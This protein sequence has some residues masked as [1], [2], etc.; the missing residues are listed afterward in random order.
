MNDRMERFDYGISIEELGARFTRLYS[1]LIYDVL[2]EMGYSYQALA[3]EI[4]P[5]RNEWVIAGPAYT[6]KMETNP[7]TD[8]SLRSKRLEMLRMM[9]PGMIE[10]RDCSN[11]DQVAHF[12]ELNANI[13]RSKGCVGAIIDGGTRDSRFV[14]DMDFP[15]FARY[16]NPVE[17]LGRAVV[18]DAMVD[19][20][21]RG[22]LSKGVTVRPYDYLFADLDGVMAIPREIV[23]TVLEKCEQE[24]KHENE[25]REMYR[26][27]G[28]DPVEI[29]KKLGKL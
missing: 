23:K 16:R 24:F 6:I 14:L 28:A 26:Q 12:G 1:G 8:R 21:V 17:A 2:D 13:V 22:A 29:Y 3:H 18:T 20:T 7:S 9:V 10:I 5:L 25:A 11:D 15:V 27:P 19:I 4:K